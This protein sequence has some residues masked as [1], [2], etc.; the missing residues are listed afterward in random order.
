MTFG[1]SKYNCK[2]TLQTWSNVH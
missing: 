2:N 1:F